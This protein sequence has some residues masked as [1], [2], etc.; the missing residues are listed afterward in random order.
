MKIRPRNH[1]AIT[2]ITESGTGRRLKWTPNYFT[3]EHP[4]GLSPLPGKI[5]LHYHS[6]GLGHRT[7]TL[8]FHR[9]VA[10]LPPTPWV[11]PL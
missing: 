9:I 6:K 1:D 7:F 2:V 4:E 10:V 3:I 5:T 8:H 11:V